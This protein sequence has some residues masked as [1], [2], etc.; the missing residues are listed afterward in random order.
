MAKKKKVRVRITFEDNREIVTLE[1]D[2]LSEI[3]YPV[4]IIE[5]IT[6]ISY[7]R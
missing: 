5:S 2:S 6:V 1:I 4:D 7:R 3:P